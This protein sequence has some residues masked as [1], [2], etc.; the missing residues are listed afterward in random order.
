VPLYEYQCRECGKR[1]EAFVTASHVPVCPSCKSENLEKLLSVFGVSGSSGTGGWN[2]SSK[3]DC[4]PG[5]G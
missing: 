2:S 1:F 3:G 4:S 5:G